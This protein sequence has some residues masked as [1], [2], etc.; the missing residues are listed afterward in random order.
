MNEYT[1]V[2]H[3]PCFVGVEVTTRIIIRGEP[4]PR[5]NEFLT[6]ATIDLFSLLHWCKEWM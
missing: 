3:H 4:N 6:V 1:Y 2:I 5:T